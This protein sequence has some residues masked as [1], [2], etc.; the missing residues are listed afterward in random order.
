MH[1]TVDINAGR[2][3]STT[4]MAKKNKKRVVFDAIPELRRQILNI[5][6]ENQT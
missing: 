4:E 3:A 5:L 6:Y 2:G 1:V